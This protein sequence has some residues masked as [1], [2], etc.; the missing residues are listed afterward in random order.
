M[1]M[2][3]HRV[4]RC[5]AKWWVGEV[6]SGSTTG[7]GVQE[8]VIFTCLSD[9]KAPSRSHPIPADVLNDLPHS[10]LCVILRCAEQWD[11]RLE[12][13]PYNAP[14]EK[15]LPGPHIVDDEGLR[16]GFLP[17]QG[18]I[19]TTAVPELRPSLG[20]VCLDD[21]ALRHEI[22]FSD[23][24]AMRSYLSAPDQDTTHKIIKLHRSTLSKSLPSPT[25][26]G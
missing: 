24:A 16:W 6:H 8:S 21:S 23:D 7:A 12:M 15:R 14:D 19:V 3:D 13:Y 20:F 25:E 10:T 5:D 9:L 11:D 2:Y 22:V 4:F 18:V 1:A 17:R 26:G